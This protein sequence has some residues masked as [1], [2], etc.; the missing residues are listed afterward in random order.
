MRMQTGLPTLR[1]DQCLISQGSTVPNHSSEID[2]RNTHSVSIIDPLLIANAL[3]AGLKNEILMNKKTLRKMMMKTQ[4]KT[5]KTTTD[6]QTRWILVRF[7]TILMKRLMMT[8][9]MLC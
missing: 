4:M 9:K 8:R 1:L 2:N 7:P 5:M 3:A 6:P